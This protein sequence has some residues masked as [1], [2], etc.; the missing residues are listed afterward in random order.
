MVLSIG[1]Q[2][3]RGDISG[4]IKV[5]I[6]GDP[7]IWSE[8][9][10]T[11]TEEKH[12]SCRPWISSVRK[13]LPRR[14]FTG[15]WWEKL[16]LFPISRSFNPIAYG[17][18][19]LSQLRGGFL[20]HTPENNVKIIWLVRNLVHIINSIRILRMRNFRKFA[21]L[22]LEIWSHK[23]RLFT[24]ERFIAF[25]CLPPEFVFNDAKI[26]FLLSKMIFLT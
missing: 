15:V 13:H 16:E 18:L 22:F 17:I 26:T 19:R 23:I 9:Q 5:T 2:Y 4:A 14:L 1:H 12:N 8:N 11:Q 20:S 24:R 25:R 6:T 3:F 10:S 21:V 7:W